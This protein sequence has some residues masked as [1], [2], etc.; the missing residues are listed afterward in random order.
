M[1]DY[2]LKANVSRLAG[3]PGLPARIT[4]LGC[5]ERPGC[6]IILRLR[7]LSP[8]AR[9]LSQQVLRT[10]DLSALRPAM[11]AYLD[12]VGDD[13]H[14]PAPTE[15]TRSLDDDIVRGLA[16]RR[17]HNLDAADPV[18]V[19]VRPIAEPAVE[20]HDDLVVHQP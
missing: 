1:S 9:D 3:L 2:F 17:E 14:L 10:T 11:L 19:D 20:D 12:V 16:A 6:I 5:R 18:R 4:T 13:D 7:R 8:T 15:R